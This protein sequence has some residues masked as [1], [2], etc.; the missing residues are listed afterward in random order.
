M[1]VVR[2]CTW[3]HKTLP[4]VPAEPCLL[5]YLIPGDL[6]INLIVPNA[7]GE[8]PDLIPGMPYL[9]ELVQQQEEREEE[10]DNAVV[11][12]MEYAPPPLTAD[13]ETQVEWKDLPVPPSTHLALYERAP[14]SV[15][16]SQHNP[17]DQQSVTSARR[18]GSERSV[19]SVRSVVS[20]V[21]PVAPLSEA[22]KRRSASRSSAVTLTAPSG[23][24]KKDTKPKRKRARRT[25]DTFSG[26]NVPI[27]LSPETCKVNS[28]NARTNGEYDVSDG[29]SLDEG[30]T[31]HKE[32]V[33]SDL[34]G[35]EGE[36]SL[37][38]SHLSH[39]SAFDSQ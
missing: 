4:Y 39:I 25:T 14:A 16:A 22:K 13:V 19:T 20:D 33:S 11:P 30:A 10:E 18:A 17:I 38:V 31:L 23:E 2:P 32:D 28:T 29:S 21:I 7:R 27:T 6:V 8:Y 34:L 15:A 1:P 26:L 12:L 24:G 5:Y 36:A 9:E 37:D 35:D 3:D